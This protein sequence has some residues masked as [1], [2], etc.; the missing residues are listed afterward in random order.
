[1]ILREIFLGSRRFDEFQRY[2]GAS[3]HSLSQRLKQLCADEILQK[4]QY[5]DHPPR[6]E[7][8]LTQKGRD[9][10]PVI[11]ALKTW[12]DT[13]MDVDQPIDLVHTVCGQVM[14]PQIIC[15]DCGD[16]IEARH[17]RAQVGPDLAAEREQQ[18]K[19]A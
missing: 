2:T 4:R 11:I 10:W 3:P 1:M 14:T 13:W 6:F 8:H 5:S 17:C 15:P 12:G 7:Y 18:G 19:Q 9:L 16:P